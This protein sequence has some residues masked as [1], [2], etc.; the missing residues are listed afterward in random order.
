[1]VSNAT[2]RRKVRVESWVE[3]EKKRYLAILAKRR[4][5][6][7]AAEIRAMIDEAMYFDEEKIKDDYDFPA[8]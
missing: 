6:S 2:K 5:R 3:P 8:T 4:H 7:V 1:M